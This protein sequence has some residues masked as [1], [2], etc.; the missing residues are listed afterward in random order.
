MARLVPMLAILTSLIVCGCSVFSAEQNLDQSEAAYARC[1]VTSTSGEGDCES[2]KQDVETNKQIYDQAS[3]QSPFLIGGR[4]F[5]TFT[6]PNAN[7][8]PNPEPE[9]EPDSTQDQ[10]N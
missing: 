9:Q 8:N 7:P 1:Q 10:D 3:T 2:L 4:R 6:R 5:Q